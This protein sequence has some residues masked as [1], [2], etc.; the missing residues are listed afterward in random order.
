MKKTY[1]FCILLMIYNYSFANDFLYVERYKPY[2][3]NSTY[4]EEVLFY[5]DGLIKQITRYSIKEGIDFYNWNQEKNQLQVLESFF[6]ERTDSTITEYHIK[7]TTKEVVRK[8]E[9]QSS[10]IWEKTE[11]KNKGEE[12]TIIDL[13]RNNNSNI[14]NTHLNFWGNNSYLVD[15]VLYR[16]FD[17]S[18]SSFSNTTSM[19]YIVSFDKKNV[20]TIKTNYPYGEECSWICYISGYIPFSKESTYFNCDIL[21]S[22]NVTSMVFFSIPTISKKENRYYNN[23]KEFSYSEKIISLDN[24]IINVQK[25]QDNHGME[26]IYDELNKKYL[27][28]KSEDI[29]FFYDKENTTPIFI[30]NTKDKLVLKDF[31]I[32]A[33][34]FLKEKTISYISDNLKS[35]KLKE[36][37]VEGAAGNGEGEYIIFNKGK[38]NG[39]YIINGFISMDR[40]DLYEKNN[41]VEKIEIE[42]ITSKIKTDELL[43][44]TSKPQFFDLSNYLQ[45]EDIKITIKSIYKG[46]LYEDTCLGGIILIE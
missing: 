35:L 12:K 27:I 42:G 43:L 46:S 2:A 4:F 1:L 36:P 10:L 37:W 3:R 15:N 8:Y 21:S 45:N 13:S 17:V 20:Y 11:K 38:A 32:K 24:K 26:Y 41:R 6:I 28:L 14:N 18:T 44:D 34:S 9:K 31:S 23:G 39:L 7:G 30:G 22:S 33:S 29:L 5:D 40:P 19:E 25:K 16:M